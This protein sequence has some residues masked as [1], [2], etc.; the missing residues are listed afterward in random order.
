MNKFQFKSK[1]TGSVFA[2]ET[3]N[4]ASDAGEAARKVAGKRLAQAQRKNEEDDREI[5]IAFKKY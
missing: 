2:P 3:S 4:S 5:K 1:A